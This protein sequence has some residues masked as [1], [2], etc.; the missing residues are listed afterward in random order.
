MR[1]LTIIAL[2][3]ALSG[4]WSSSKKLPEPA[5]DV[6]LSGAEANYD[7]ISN[8]IDSRVA[9][10]IIVAKDNAKDEKT[11]TGELSVAQAMLD[12]PS[13]DDLAWAKARAEKGDEV[14]YAEQVKQARQLAAAM[15]AASKNYEAE[16]AR[17][18]A[19]FDAALIAKDKEFKALE[20]S[21]NNDRLMF[22]GGASLAAGLALMFFFPIAKGKQF[23]AVLLIVGVI[24][25]GIPFVSGES[26]FKQAIGWTIAIV[27]ILIITWFILSRKKECS[28]Q[29]T[30]DN[31]TN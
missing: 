18:Q 29:P 26:W 13:P 4:C 21:K 10:A 3:L 8:K 2:S 22:A 30:N 16:K 19:E 20:L 12:A 14:F 27:I 23:G 28:A 5:T 11:V 24:L 7:K 17:K 1:S 6:G 31:P 9:A 25:G 15:I